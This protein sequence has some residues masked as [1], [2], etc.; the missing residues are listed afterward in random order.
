[1]VIVNV[2]AD[3]LSEPKSKT[4]IDLLPWVTL[5]INAHLAVIAPVHEMFG[6]PT[7]AVYPEDDTV[8]GVNCAPPSEYVPVAG[9]SSVEL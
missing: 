5:Y 2:P 8:M 6:K 1:M 9:T 4:A 7:Y 3:V